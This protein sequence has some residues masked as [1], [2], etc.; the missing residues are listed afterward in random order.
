MVVVPLTSVWEVDTRGPTEWSG[1]AGKDLV[2]IN[3]MK[4]DINLC[5]RMHV[6]TSGYIHVQ[7]HV[8][9]E[10]AYMHAHTDINQ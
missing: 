9:C 6:N 4:E 7:L 10:L 3:K 5:P 8:Q 1:Y 2:S